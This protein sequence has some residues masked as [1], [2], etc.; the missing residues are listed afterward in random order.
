GSRRDRAKYRNFANSK[1][2][3]TPGSTDPEGLPRPALW[4][5]PAMAYDYNTLAVTLDG[6]VLDVLLDRPDKRNAITHEMQ[7]EI[8]AVLDEAEVDDAVRA[9][10]LRGSGVVFSAGHDLHDNER[11]SFAELRA[12]F[13]SP[14]RAP[15]MLR[16]WYF[17]KPLIA[18]VHGYVGPYA[19]A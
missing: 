3:P 15:Q 19:L 4:H 1:G 16:A 18:A 5:R 11:Q 2:R 10:V 17:R 12:P 6:G 7:D 14:S 13:A 8:D 9:V